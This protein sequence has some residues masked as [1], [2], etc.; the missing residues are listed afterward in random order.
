MIVCLVIFCQPTKLKAVNKTTNRNLF[1]AVHDLETGN[2]FFDGVLAAHQKNLA[3]G[4][5]YDV[6]LINCWADEKEAILMSLFKAMGS[7]SVIHSHKEAHGLLPAAILKVTQGN[8]WHK[9]QKSFLVLH[10]TKLFC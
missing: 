10:H 9:F 3:T 4:T 7:T 6:S 5:K 1:I 8:N 2:V